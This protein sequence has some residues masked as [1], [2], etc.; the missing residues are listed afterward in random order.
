MIENISEGGSDSQKHYMYRW[1]E[2][3]SFKIVL[4]IFN[5]IQTLSCDFDIVLKRWNLNNE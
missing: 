5:Q 4:N 1:G 3:G 2:F